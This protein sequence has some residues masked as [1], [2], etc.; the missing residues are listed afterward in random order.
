M[1]LRFV[2][3]YFS[4]QA[5]F[6][7]YT[8]GQGR[9]RSNWLSLGVFFLLRLLLSIILQIIFYFFGAEYRVVLVIHFVSF[10]TVVVQKSESR[11]QRDHLIDMLPFFGV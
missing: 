10:F 5:G 3:D 4:W 1:T 6:V 7:R 2:F 8:L 11:D 9:R